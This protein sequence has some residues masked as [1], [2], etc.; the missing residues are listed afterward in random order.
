MLKK[1]A[2][3]WAKKKA[4]VRSSLVAVIPFAVAVI[5]EAQQAKKI[6]RWGIYQ[7]QPH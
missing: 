5:V 2:S 1:L 7:G 3:E 6:L 4:A